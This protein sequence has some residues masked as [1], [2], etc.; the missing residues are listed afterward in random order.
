MLIRLP[1]PQCFCPRGRKLRPWSEKNSD[2]NS[3]HPRLCIH[4]GKEN[5]DHGLNFGCFWGRRR[6]GGSQ[7]VVLGM[8]LTLDRAKR[9][10]SYA[11]LPWRPENAEICHN[12]TISLAPYRG[13]SGPK[14]PQKKTGPLGPRAKKGWKKVEKKVEKSKEGCFCF[15]PEGPEWPL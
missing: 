15:G 14:S 3:D 11:F 8:T 5:S 1:V 7:P 9:L 13:H 10:C 2:Q 4:Q 6:R 12:V